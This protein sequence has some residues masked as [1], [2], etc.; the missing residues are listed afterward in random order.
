MDRCRSSASDAL[1]LFRLE[2]MPEFTGM[3][4]KAVVTVAGTGRNE[5]DTQNPEGRRPLLGL[6]IRVPAT[7]QGTLK[8]FEP[9][10]HFVDH[11]IGSG[12][13]GREPND[14]PLLKPIGTQFARACDLIGWPAELPC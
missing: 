12:S 3:P 9:Y 5:V 13:A 2:A 10:A 6:P 14:L 1:S 8:G 4:E 11:S 7:Q